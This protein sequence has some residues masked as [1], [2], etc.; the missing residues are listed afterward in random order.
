MMSEISFE[1]LHLLLGG[2]DVLE[3]FLAQLLGHPVSICRPPEVA[4]PWYNIHCIPDIRAVGV[5]YSIYCVF[6]GPC[7]MWELMREMQQYARHGEGVPQEL[8]IIMFCREEP[9]G[10]G[11]NYYRIGPAILN[12]SSVVP[13][14]GGNIY[15]HV[16][17]VSSATLSSAAPGEVQQLLEVLGGQEVSYETSPL[18]EAMSQVEVR[19]MWLD[20]LRQYKKEIFVEEYTSAISD[21][22]SRFDAAEFAAVAEDAFEE[23]YIK[24]RV[25]RI[26]TFP[27][28][29]LKGIPTL[30]DDMQ[31]LEP[32]AKYLEVSV[33]VIQGVLEGR[34]Y[35]EEDFRKMYGK[36]R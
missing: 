36:G 33:E 14:M 8:H 32:L 13:V 2:Q 22:F 5:D 23:A 1:R 10:G 20:N 34:V 4:L 17:V 29:L 16:L 11:Q 35:T 21:G 9:F 3:L 15:Y 27:K 6:I 24:A 7:G 18:L 25:E 26:N 31:T 12:S 30:I 19:W 28:D